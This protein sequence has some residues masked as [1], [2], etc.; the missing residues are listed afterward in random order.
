M[1]T[2]LSEVSYIY[3]KV[4]HM[5]SFPVSRCIFIYKLFNHYRFHRT[6]AVGIKDNSVATI[7]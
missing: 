4:L 2:E 5:F 3:E 1:W 7:K 6:Q